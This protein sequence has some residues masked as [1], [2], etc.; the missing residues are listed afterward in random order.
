MYWRSCTW[1]AG[2][3]PW[4]HQLSA[5]TGRWPSVGRRPSCQAHWTSWCRAHSGDSSPGSLKS[6]E[7][8]GE[9]GCG[10]HLGR[11]LGLANKIKERAS[12]ICTAQDFCKLEGRSDDI[13]KSVSALT[14]AQ[15]VSSLELRRHLFQ[16]ARGP[17]GVQAWSGWNITHSDSPAN[18]CSHQWQ[19]RAQSGCTCLSFPAPVLHAYTRFLGS[20]VKTRALLEP[21]PSQ[22]TWVQNPR[23]K[24]SRLWL[25]DQKFMSE[26][27]PGGT[28]CNTHTWRWRQ[29]R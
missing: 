22:W 20:S 12:T 21:C 10:N 19:H 8:L 14:K 28:S 17:R 25:A 26:A 2:G 6:P 7:N 18:A 3:D 16:R 15:R 24:V 11:S 1:R 4:D 27:G 5:K 9:G 13:I 29:E 23:E